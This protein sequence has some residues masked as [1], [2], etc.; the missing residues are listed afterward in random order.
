[1]F[2]LAQ[3]TSLPSN[4]AGFPVDSSQPSSANAMKFGLARWVLP[5]R[6]RLTRAEVLV[7]GDPLPRFSEAR[8]S[9]HC[10][11]E[12]SAILPTNGDDRYTIQD[13]SLHRMTIC[14]YV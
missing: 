6:G 11:A 5:T 14:T 2:L 13:S 9:A 12:L 1:M 8:A 7:W 3:P 4:G 10:T